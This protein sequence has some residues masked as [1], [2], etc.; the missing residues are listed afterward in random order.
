MKQMSLATG[1]EKESKRTR[2]LEFSD[3]MD[4]VVP[5]HELVTPIKSHISPK[6]TDRPAFGVD[7]YAAYPPAAAVVQP[8]GPGS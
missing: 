8:L 1:F 7:C 5:W 6:A 2:K 4:L 3:E